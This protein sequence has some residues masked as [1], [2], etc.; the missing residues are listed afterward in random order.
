MCLNSYPNG[1]WIFTNT[2]LVIRCVYIGWKEVKLM[3]Y[4][5]FKLT[6]KQ[7][8]EFKSL[9]ESGYSSNHGPLSFGEKV[10]MH[11]HGAAA[12]YLVK[13]VAQFSGTMVKRVLGNGKRVN[14]VLVSARQK[15][16]WKDMFG[17]TV[18]DQVF[19]QKLVSRV[20]TAA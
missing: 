2:F 7:L 6:P 20:L 19:G 13:G 1:I 15:H 12:M 17:G 16:G 9:K 14:S 18:I 10:Q 3:N 5:F 11:S 4:Q 8:E